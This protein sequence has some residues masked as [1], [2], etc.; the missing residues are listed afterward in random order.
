[1]TFV[2]L[3]R[4]RPLDAGIENPPGNRIGRWIVIAVLSLL[5][6]TAGVI[7]YL[8]WTISNADVPMSGYVAM[9]L[10]VIFSLAVGVGLMALVFNSSRKGTGDADPGLG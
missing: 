10:G 6:A 8:G 4:N 5:L 2:P 1:M 3:T 7:G 9:A